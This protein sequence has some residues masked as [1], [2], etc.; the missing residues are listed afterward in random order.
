MDKEIDRDWDAEDE[1]M[2]SERRRCRAR[3]ESLER[4]LNP[5]DD[6]KA[7][8]SMWGESSIRHDSDSEA[9]SEYELLLDPN[10]PDELSSE[11][12]LR[13]PNRDSASMDG[14]AQMKDAGRGGFAVPGGQGRRSQLRRGPALQHRQSLGDRPVPDLPRRLDEYALLPEESI[15]QPRLP[16]RSDHRLAHWTRVGQG[17]AQGGSTTPLA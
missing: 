9:G 14:E 17:H 8:L 6:L 1:V 15:H 13:N 2:A 10:L 16:G 7:R 12:K 5:V 4:R 3:Q 11:N